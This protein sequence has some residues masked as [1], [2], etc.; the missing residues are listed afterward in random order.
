MKRGRDGPMREGGQLSRPFLLRPQRGEE[1]C[2]LLYTSI[3]VSSPLHESAL[4]NLEPKRALVS[5]NLLVSDGDSV[6]LQPE[7]ND[8][9]E[10]SLVDE[11][12]SDVGSS[13]VVG[14]AGDGS[15]YS[16]FDRKGE[17]RSGG[18]GED[19]EEG[20]EKKRAMHDSVVVLE[21]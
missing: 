15:Y 20:R 2:L 1:H 21:W 19:G 18:G 4:A 17:G 9:L 13:E 3:R 7:L 10:S 14:R 16:R 6:L 11:E 5:S 12:T 8:L